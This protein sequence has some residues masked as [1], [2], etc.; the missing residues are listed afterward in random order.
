MVEVSFRPG[1]YICE[2]GKPGNSFYIVVEGVCRVT[3][4]DADGPGQQREV[5]CANTCNDACHAKCVCFLCVFDVWVVRAC[6]CA[7]VCVWCVCVCMGVCHATCACGR[8]YVPRCACARVLCAL[9]VRCAS[10]ECVHASHVCSGG[11]ARA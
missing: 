9:C 3:V 10:V 1:A 8:D 5:R 6:A 11:C 7:C 4:K 2:Q